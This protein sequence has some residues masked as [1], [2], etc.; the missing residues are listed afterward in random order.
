MTLIQVSSSS[1]KLVGLQRIAYNVTSEYDPQ[2]NERGEK[3]DPIDRLEP[4]SGETRFI[5]IPDNCDQLPRNLSQQEGLP[6]D[7]QK[8]RAPVARNSV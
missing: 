7:I 3:E 4:A 6:V 1:T 8:D 5:Q 2:S